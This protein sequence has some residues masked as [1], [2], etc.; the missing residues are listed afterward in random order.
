MADK[1]IFGRLP[2][3]AP[4]GFVLSTGKLFAGTVQI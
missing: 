3:P 4:L 1:E 2:D